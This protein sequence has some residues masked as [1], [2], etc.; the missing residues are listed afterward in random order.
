M[1]YI[2]SECTVEEYRKAIYSQDAKHKLYIKVGNTVLDN[3]DSF[4]EKLVWRN[5]LLDVNSKN[6]HLDNFVSKSVE[7]ILHDYLIQDLKSEIEIKIGTYINQQVGYVY[8]PLGLYKIQD[9]PTTDKN[10]TTYKLRDR[11][12]N[13]DFKY[14]AKDLIDSSTHID[15]TG[16]KYVTKLEI[17]DDICSKA[18]MSY[19][20][21]RDFVGCDD[22]VAIYDNTINARIYLS[23]IFEQAGRIATI[24]REGNLTS[25]LINN[26]LDVHKL[27]L[28]LIESYTYSGKYKISKTIYESGNIKWEDGTD[29]YDILYINTANPYIANQ[30]QLSRIQ[31]LVNDFEIDSFKVSKI[32]GNPAIDSYDFITV[33]NNNIQLSTKNETTK[34]EWDGDTSGKEVMVFEELGMT[35][36]KVS[37]KILNKEDLIGK[38]YIFSYSDGTNEEIEILE[39]DY[40]KATDGRQIISYSGYIP[41]IV[42]VSETTE[43]VPY[44]TGTYFFKLDAGADDYA[45]VSKFDVEIDREETTKPFKTLAQNTLTYNGKIL[46]SFE[47]NIEYEAKQSN[48]SNTGEATLKKY[49]KTEIDNVNASIKTEATRIDNLD[50]VVKD[51]NQKVLDKFKN[52]TPLSDTAT[53]TQSVVDLQT[54]TYKKI[55]VNKI[56]NGEFYDENNKQIVNTITKTTSGTFDENGLTIEKTGAQTKGNFN[57][58]GIT[59]IDNT[60]ASGQELLFAGYD[61][62]LKETIVRTKNIRVTKYLNIGSNSRIEDYENGTGIF[63]VGGDD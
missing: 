2:P 4:C 28:E 1:A 56:L 59:V 27:P 44:S 47:T 35:L 11:A 24:D 37:D 17:L 5:L 62:E 50:A 8:V 25:I 43:E 55:E 48:V 7:L 53:L 52:Y 22:A 46:Q 29:D 61:E 19:V 12:V 57:E 38:T 10:K 31:P 51:N 26:N 33:P 21:D 23:Y 32:I 18:N 15:A 20:G 36:Y 40:G 16:S 60:G 34:I 9:T 58:K 39:D 54:N 45:Y 14:N 13:F 6:F 49:V 42:I 3:P 63:Y 30:Q 41:V